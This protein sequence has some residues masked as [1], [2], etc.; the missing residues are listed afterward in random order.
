MTFQAVLR[1]TDC[2]RETMNQPYTETSNIFCLPWTACSYF[3]LNSENGIKSLF[4]LLFGIK[5]I[6]SNSRKLKTQV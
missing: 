1:L 4:T 3:N 5:S 2:L 6:K